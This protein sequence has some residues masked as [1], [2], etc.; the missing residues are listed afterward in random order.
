MEKN[1]DRRAVVD[2]C[3]HV[4][5]KLLQYPAIRNYQYITDNNSRFKADKGMMDALVHLRKKR[6]AGGRGE[7][8]NAG[9]SV[10]AT[11]LWGM[12]AFYAD[13]AGGRLAIT[14]PSS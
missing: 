7:A 14:R 2:H 11:L 13:D 12:Y 5:Q 6:G 9:E 4:I 3:I 8:K 10:L 1:T